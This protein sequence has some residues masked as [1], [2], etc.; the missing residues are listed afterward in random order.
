MTKKDIL[1][2]LFDQKLTRILAVFVNKPRD[3][4]LSELSEAGNV[5]VATT[6]RILAKLTKLNIIK[7]KKIS[8]FKLY[9]LSNS[10]EAQFISS[11]FLE[12]QNSLDLFVANAKEDKR[13]ESI[14]IQGEEGEDKANLIIIGSHIDASKLDELTEKIQ[15]ETGFQ[16]SF[17]PVDSEQFKKMTSMGLYSGKKSVIYER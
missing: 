8:K 16:I 3:Y 9:S 4:Y 10:E 13:I 12:K 17:V 5:P 2:K 7:I 6:Y 1:T 11:L 15:K 14:I